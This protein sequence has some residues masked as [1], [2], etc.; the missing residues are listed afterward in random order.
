MQTGL[1]TSLCATVDLVVYL[2]DVSA[3]AIIKSSYSKCQSYFLTAHGT[4][5]YSLRGIKHSDGMTVIYY[6]MRHSPSYTRTR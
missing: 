4:V 6:L 1:L 5:G 3:D 2:T